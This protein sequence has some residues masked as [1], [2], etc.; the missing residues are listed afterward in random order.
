M[1]KGADIKS[2]GLF[3]REFLASFWHLEEGLSG[4]ET[5]QTVC[6]GLNGR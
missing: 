3:V 2:K 6:R 5:D 1:L 4:G